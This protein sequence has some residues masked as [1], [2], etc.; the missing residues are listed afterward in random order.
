L[1]GKVE[2]CVSNEILEEYEE[3]L[4]EKSSPLLA[5][6]VLN[7]IIN[8]ENLVLVSPSFFFR[9]I[10]ADPDDNKFVDCAICGNAEFI[11]SNDNHFKILKQIKFPSVAVKR[12]EEYIEEIK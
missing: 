4:A 10:E 11:V 3:K 12:I 8:N 5:E 7:S 1:Y 9:L 6:S 2:W